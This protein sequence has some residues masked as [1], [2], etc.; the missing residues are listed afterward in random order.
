MTT[1]FA[2]E[3][4][5]SSLERASLAYQTLV[6][7]READIKYCLWK[8]FDRLKEG[9]RGATDFDILME[10][11]QRQLVFNTLR[12]NGWCE[13]LSEPWRRFPDVHD[14]LQYDPVHKKF[15]HFHVHFRLVMGEKLIKSLSLPLESLYLKTAVEGEGIFYAM[16]ELEMCVFILRLSLK[17]SLRDYARVIRRRDPRRIYLNL[18]PEFEHIHPRCDRD[19]LKALLEDPAFSFIDGNL[20]LETFDDI[21][22]LNYSRRR[23]IKRCIAP[24]RRYGTLMRFWVHLSRSSQKKSFGLGK[25]LPK[26][27]LSFAFCGPDGSGKTTL[28]DSIEN[29]LRR[30]FKVARFYMGGNNSSRDLPRWIF[31][32]GFRKLFLGIRKLCRILG[33]QPGVDRIERLYFGYTNY[34]MAKEKQNRYRRGKSEAERGAIVLYERFPLFQGLGGDGGSL[35]GSACFEK[36]ERKCYDQI[37]APDIIFVLQVDSENAIER[38]PDHLPEVIRKKTTAF[39]RFIEKNSS[40][41]NLVIIDANASMDFILETALDPINAKLKA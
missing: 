3:T 20:V 38:K 22:S 19:L 16:P 7:L 31:S 2:P 1:Q 21:H 17:V 41:S 8:S 32:I 10:K 25:V 15:I 29:L 28:V 18:I 36:N 39:E 37:G 14:F 24:Y 30:H 4:S 6:G 26:Q 23:Q 27:G 35:S 40:N 34:L 13:V 12:Q 11:E 33:F 5:L 9:I